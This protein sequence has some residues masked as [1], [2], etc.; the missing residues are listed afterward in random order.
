MTASAINEPAAPSRAASL[1]LWL[2]RRAAP[3]IVFAAL[4]ALWESAVHLTGIKEYLLPPP[5]K[6][7]TEFLKRSDIVMARPSSPRRRSSPATCWRSW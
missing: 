1:G 5:S 6:V 3:L 7:W 4:F 2:R